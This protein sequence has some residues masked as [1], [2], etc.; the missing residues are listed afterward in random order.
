MK[1]LRICRRCGTAVRKT[2]V[3]GYYYCPHHDENV[4]EHDTFLITIPPVEFTGLPRPN[5]NHNHQET[6]P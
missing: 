1:R 6:T 3:A 2:K 5:K 4:F